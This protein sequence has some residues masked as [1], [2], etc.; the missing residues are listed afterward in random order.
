LCRQLEAKAR[1]LSAADMALLLE[2]EQAL[3]DF[4]DHLQH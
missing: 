2:L 3:E 4:V 1:G